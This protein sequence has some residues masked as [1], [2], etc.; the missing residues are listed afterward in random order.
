MGVR[1]LV[2]EMLGVRE[3]DTLEGDTDG[4][5]ETDAVREEDGVGEMREGVGD[6]DTLEGEGDRDPGDGL[7]GTGDGTEEATT[8]PLATLGAGKPTAPLAVTAHAVT[9]GVVVLLATA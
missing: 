4:D 8:V 1:E 7:A 6:G 2:M 3:G 5:R 9:T